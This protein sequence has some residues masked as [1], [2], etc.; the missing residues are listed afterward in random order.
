MNEELKTVLFIALAIL[1]VGGIMRS[2]W[3]MLKNSER[4][5]DDVDRGKL[6][7]LDDDGWDK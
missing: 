3:R 6:K 7:Q 1:I 4:M 2:S 5:L